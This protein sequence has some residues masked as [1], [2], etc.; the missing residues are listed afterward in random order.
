[1]KP[2]TKEW[3]EKAEGDYRVAVRE[4]SAKKP[5]YDAVCFH[6]Q[7]CAEKYLKAILQENEIPFPKTHDL[8]A[9]SKLC[10][11]FLPGLKGYHKGL[12]ALS[13]FA[14]AF[15]YPG[16]LASAEEARVSLGT[17]RSLRTLIRQHLGL[18]RRRR[19]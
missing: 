1:M 10:L 18:Q 13:T 4:I 6:S 8:A 12:A 7:Q 9:L 11:P 14:V 5:V 19:R 3:V 15:R 2:Q 17:M 16:D